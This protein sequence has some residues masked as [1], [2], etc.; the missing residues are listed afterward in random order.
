MFELTE[1]P[2]RTTRPSTYCGK[3]R[4]WLIAHFEVSPTILRTTVGHRKWEL[5]REVRTY[6]R[7]CT[8]IWFPAF[9][10]VDDFFS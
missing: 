5:D 4:T 10:Q 1:S 3:P 6:L 7:N 9:V 2:R 8:K